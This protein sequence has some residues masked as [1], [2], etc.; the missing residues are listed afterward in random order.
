MQEKHLLKF[1]FIAFFTLAMAQCS[2]VANV[3]PTGIIEN[4]ATY[5]QPMT[6]I[7]RSTSSVTPTM[8]LDQL[9]YGFLN[10]LK[11]TNCNLPCLLGIVPGITTTN[12][13]HNLLIPFLSLSNNGSLPVDSMGGLF[14]DYKINTFN[15]YLD[16]LYFPSPSEPGALDHIYLQTDAVSSS[17]ALDDPKSFTSKDYGDLFKRY[18]LKVILSTFGRPTQVLVSVTPSTGAEHDVASFFDLRLAYPEKGFYLSYYSLANEQD[19]LYI[20][21]PSDAFVTIWVEPPINVESLEDIIVKMDNWPGILSFI[22]FKPL[23]EA[24][25]IT[26]EQFYQT[27]NQLTNECI[28][29]TKSIWLP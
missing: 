16:F 3:H 29:T 26:N 24:T 2:P 25:G 13:V 17:S 4:T 28:E 12:E 8:P 21:C 11:N 7:P 20:G 6:L 1:G 23:N 27:F 5:T 10:L 9:Y 18:S 19:N 22:K 14:I 15:I